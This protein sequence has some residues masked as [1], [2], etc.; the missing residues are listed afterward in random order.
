[1]EEKGCVNLIPLYSGRKDG[2][3]VLSAKE[4]QHLVDN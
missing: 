1:M 3:S 2:E 4:Q